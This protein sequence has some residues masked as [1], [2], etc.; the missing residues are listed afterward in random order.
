MNRPKSGQQTNIE[1]DKTH[2]HCCA[3]RA[4]HT[5]V[6]TIIAVFNAFKPLIH[7]GL[8][9]LAMPAH[10][11]KMVY[12]YSP[13]HTG[14]QHYLRQLATAQFEYDLYQLLSQEVT[15]HTINREQTKHHLCT[16]QYMSGTAKLTISHWFMSAP[17]SINILAV[18]VSP[19]SQAIWS[20]ELLYQRSVTRKNN[21]Y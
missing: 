12:Y 21:A 4:L 8:T 16:S 2:Q 3:A 11:E 9:Q 15:F 19:L 5:R 7:C 6:C 14:S 13:Y 10:F 1:T 20:G 17:L 18:S